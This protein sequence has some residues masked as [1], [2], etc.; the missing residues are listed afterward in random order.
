MSCAVI[1]VSTYDP[2]YLAISESL[3]RQRSP[4]E[5][6]LLCSTRELSWRRAFASTGPWRVIQFPLP[7]PTSG[8]GSGRRL[9]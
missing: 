1:M 4:L 8:S 2:V 9:R 5:I 7:F 6:R 3:F